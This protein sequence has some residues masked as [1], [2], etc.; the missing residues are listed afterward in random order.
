VQPIDETT[1]IARADAAIIGSALYVGQ[2]L[3]AARQFV[4]E[5]TIVLLPL[6]QQGADQ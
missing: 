1:V 2:W 3:P 6:V 5:R 4:G